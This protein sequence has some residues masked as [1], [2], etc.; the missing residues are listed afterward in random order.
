LSAAVVTTIVAMFGAAVCYVFWRS[1][2][3]QIDDELR[4]RA[5]TIVRS[6]EPRGGG[7][8]DLSLPDDALEYFQQEPYY[9]IW[10]PDLRAIDVSDLAQ[11]TGMPDRLGTRLRDGRREIVIRTPAGVT[12]LVGRDI[13]SVRAAV[14]SLAVTIGGVGLAAAVLSVLCGWL[15][16]GRALAPL[17]RINRTARAMADGDLAARIPVD[18]TETEL[19][20]VALALNSAFARMDSAMEQ[21]RRFTADASHELRTPVATLLAETEWALGRPRDAEAYRDSLVTCRTAASRIGGVVQ[22]LLMLA[23]ADADQL[24]LALAA[25]RLDDLVGEVV[26]LARPIAEQ[27]QVQIETSVPAVQVIGDRERLHEAIANLVINAVHFNRPGGRV[28]V[29]GNR[30]AGSFV[31]RV[32]DTGIGIAPE[33]LPHVFERFYRV[34]SARGSGQGAGLG[35]AI[36]K[37][38]VERHGGTLH[39]SSLPGC[40]SEFVVTLPCGGEVVP[41]SQDQP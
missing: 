26:A 14:R 36:T 27:R 7:T 5:A 33:H 10:A 32:N 25:T 3:A 16:A 4:L 34:E 24:P 11:V 1:L 23:R 6:L 38:I 21:L 8:F 31:L 13:A 15:L 2:V 35:L 12:V 28:R 19:G 20:Q 37:W 9:G 39:G 17:A 41:Q 30:E 18:E 22:G 29:E 40:G